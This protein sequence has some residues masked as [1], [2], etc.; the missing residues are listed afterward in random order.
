MIRQEIR[1]NNEFAR[2]IRF[3]NNKQDEKDDEIIRDKL[4][5]TSQITK[6]YKDRTKQETEL[7]PLNCR[8]KETL[9]NENKFIIIEEPPRIRTTIFDIPFEREL[10]YLRLSGKLEEYG[11]TNF[12]EDNTRP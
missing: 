8:Y 5:S 7:L 12:I 1:M 9:P 2:L 10:E 11:Y 3:D 4:Y 6:M